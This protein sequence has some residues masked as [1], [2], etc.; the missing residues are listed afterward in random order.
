[1]STPR[2]TPWFD[3]A[4]EEIYLEVYAHRDLAEARRDVH[5]LAQRGLDGPFL[6][7]GCGAGRHLRAA[8][9]MGI[10]GVGVD[11]SSA[12]LA[13][14]SEQG[15]TVTRGDLRRLPFASESFSTLTC[16]FSSFG[17]FDAAGDLAQLCEAHRV[18][19]PGGSLWLDIADA[20]HV[21]RGLVPESRRQVG[22]WLLVE[23]RRLS[24]DGRRVR[25]ELALSAEGRSP[26]SWFE[27]L[28]LY[29]PQELAALL[30][31]AEL[32]VEQRWSTLG[33]AAPGAAGP[34][35][36]PRLVLRARRR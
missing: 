17:Y 18:L 34:P 7:L 29:E 4:F 23:R 1:M 32:E 6:D 27:D 28:A 10:R 9:E 20:R 5:A 36:A 30:A 13:R 19:R 14:A 31:R 25:K 15:L 33:G 22:E 35:P 26:R 16:L 2:E 8:A 21:R 11:R 3:A 12:L 24:P